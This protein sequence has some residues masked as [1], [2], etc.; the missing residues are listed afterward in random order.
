[1]IFRPDLLRA[2]AAAATLAALLAWS[3]RASPSEMPRIEGETMGTTYSVVVA[4]AAADELPRIRA[5]VEAELRAVDEAMSTY[6]ADSE[7]SRFNRHASTQPFAASP[8]LLEVFGTAREIS[9]LT[10]GAFDVTAAPLVAAWGFGATDR[11]PMPP[12]AAELAAARRAV[13]YRL[14]VVDATRGALTKL[15]PDVACDLSGIAK[16]Y[17]VDRAVAA[18]AAAGHRDVLVEIGGEVRAAGRRGDGRPWRVAIER[19]QA[20]RDAVQATLPLADRAVGTS[21]DYRAYYESGGRRFS[22]LIDPRSGQPIAN[23]VASASALHERAAVADGL[24]TAAAVLG[25]DA[26]LELAARHGWAL[27]FLVRRGDDFAEVRSEA[28]AALTALEEMP[29]K[30]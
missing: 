4:G 18:L 10:G 7:L 20:R 19:P 5:V 11:A 27:S 13:G 9:E 16:G 26:G 12:T 23:G 14:V 28:Y 22:H 1:M 25:A 6:R 3:W 24:A 8:A 2:V 15:R 21:G 30:N 17:A 29:A